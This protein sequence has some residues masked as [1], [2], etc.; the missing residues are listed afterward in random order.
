MEP[1]QYKLQ[2]RQNYFA[3]FGEFDFAKYTVLQQR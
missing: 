1:F 3:W 2:D